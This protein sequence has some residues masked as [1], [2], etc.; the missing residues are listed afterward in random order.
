[1]ATQ[2]ILYTVLLGV[3]VC[4]YM[5]FPNYWLLLLIIIH[6][7]LNLVYEGIQMYT[8]GFLEYFGFWNLF[9]IGGFGFVIIYSI[10]EFTRQ[11]GAP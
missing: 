2:S 6:S 8:G 5:S 10:G 1:M 9:D 7:F 11:K 4:V 3:H